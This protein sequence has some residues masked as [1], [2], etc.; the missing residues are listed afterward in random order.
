MQASYNIRRGLLKIKFTLD[1]KDLKRIE[2][3][4]FSMNEI[5]VFVKVN[6]R[7]AALDIHPD[8]VGLSIVLLC[9]PFVGESLVIEGEVSDNFIQSV[10][11]VLSK[12]KITRSEN[13][14]GSPPRK[15]SDGLPA[16]AFSGGADS[17]AALAVM[18]RKLFPFF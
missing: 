1:E 4:N 17:S 8:L 15:I 14:Q 16:L 3:Q 6:E 11:S 10:Q 9:N 18:P 12:Y 5:E 7:G 13:F 2:S